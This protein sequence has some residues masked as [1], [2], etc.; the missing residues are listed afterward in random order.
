MASRGN[1]AG[2][3]AA[4]NAPEPPHGEPGLR[5]Q[6]PFRTIRAHPRRFAWG[7]PLVFIVSLGAGG[8]LVEVN[9]SL[10]IAVQLAL[11]T[12]GLLWLYI[13][14]ARRPRE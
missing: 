11:Q 3:G 10:A 7:I 12:I 4:E 1:D 9:F 13:P 5:D 6:E 14:V 8:L 2:E